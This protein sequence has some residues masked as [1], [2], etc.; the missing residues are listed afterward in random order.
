MQLDAS[1]NGS[2]LHRFADFQ[3]GDTFGDFQTARE[4]GT[5]HTVSMDQLARSHLPICIISQKNKPVANAAPQTQQLLS[6]S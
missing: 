3:E 6:P 2:K 5:E 1:F 4:D